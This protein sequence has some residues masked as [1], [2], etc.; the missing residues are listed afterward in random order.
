VRP[1]GYYG[2]DITEDLLLLATGGRAGSRS[3]SGQTSGL[4]ELLLFLLRNQRADDARR[5]IERHL[6][7]LERVR[8]TRFPPRPRIERGDQDVD[9]SP[10]G[11]VVFDP[12]WL[13]WNGGTVRRMAE[14]FKADRAFAHLPV[15]AD[16]LEDAGCQDGRILRHLREPMKHDSRCWVLRLLLALEGE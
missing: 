7:W 14:S 5:I 6:D 16:A 1:A 11:E 4:L 9:G 3:S 15:L 2:D 12:A 10:L 8:S 13:K